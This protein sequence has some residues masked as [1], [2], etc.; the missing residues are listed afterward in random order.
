MLPNWA[1][2]LDLRGALTSK[3]STEGASIVI[4]LDLMITGKAPFDTEMG[5]FAGMLY[6][7]QSSTMR[8]LYIC[9]HGG[10]YDKVCGMGKLLS[11]A[12]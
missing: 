11:I 6:E 12:K 5:L 7:Q 10:A 9:L 4:G 8:K 2:Y 3:T 1:S